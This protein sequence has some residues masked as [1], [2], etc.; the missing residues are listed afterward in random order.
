MNGIPYRFVVLLSH[1]EAVS[2]G[3]RR[4]R[5]R[6]DVYVNESR[7]LLVRRVFAKK[8]ASQFG[9]ACGRFFLF[10]FLNRCTA[11]WIPRVNNFCSTDELIRCEDVEGTT[12]KISKR[13]LSVR[14]SANESTTV[15]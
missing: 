15:G 5:D 1:A 4:E 2:T 7:A 9:L 12:L 13:F 11:N 14:L 10:L 3:E 6:K 8:A